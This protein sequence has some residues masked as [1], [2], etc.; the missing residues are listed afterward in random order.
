MH[1]VNAKEI[2]SLVKLKADVRTRVNY[3]KPV[4]DKF[5]SEIMLSRGNWTNLRSGPT[6]FLMMFKKS[7]CTCPSHKYRLE[8]EIT[9]SSPA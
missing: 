6:I 8:E 2:N 3:F 5:P 4:M 9:E 1:S 7:K